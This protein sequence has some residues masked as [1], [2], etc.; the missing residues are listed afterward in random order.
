MV[1]RCTDVLRSGQ[2]RRRHDAVDCRHGRRQDPFSLCLAS[3][4]AS[5]RRCPR[6]RPDR[7]GTRA[8]AMQDDPSCRCAPASRPPRSGC[9]RRRPAAITR[10]HKKATRC[11]V[12]QHRHGASRPKRAG[13]RPS[14]RANRASL[15]RTETVRIDIHDLDQW[16]G[17][18]LPIWCIRR[19]PGEGCCVARLNR[20]CQA[21]SRQDRGLLLTYAGILGVTHFLPSMGRGR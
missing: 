10:R 13:S 4:A 17:E 3:P 14:I 16:A 21:V 12:S 9:R 6:G 15:I 7:V 11:E 1:I 19:A 18:A 2:E 8:D 5:S 20:G